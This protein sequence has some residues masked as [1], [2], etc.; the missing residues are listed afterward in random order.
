MSYKVTRKKKSAVN[1]EHPYDWKICN[2][3]IYKKSSLH[4][5]LGKEVV[6]Q[7]IANKMVP[8]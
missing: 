1:N 6:L 3:K 5:L 8:T 7:K 2:K 4:E